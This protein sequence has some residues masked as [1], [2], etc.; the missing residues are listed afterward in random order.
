MGQQIF[1]PLYTLVG[2][3][4]FEYNITKRDKEVSRRIKVFREVSKQFV[5]ERLNEIKTG[6]SQKED[7][8]SKIYKIAD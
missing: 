7:Y 8:I 3:G 4:I 5:E 1:D 2:P 6:E